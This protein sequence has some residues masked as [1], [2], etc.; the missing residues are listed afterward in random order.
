MNKD[1]RDGNVS[2]SFRRWAEIINYCCVNRFFLNAF[3]LVVSSF[4]EICKAK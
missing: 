1:G 2:F 4:T 3:L